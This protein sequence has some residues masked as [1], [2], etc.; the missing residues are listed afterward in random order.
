MPNRFLKE[1]IRTSKT[2]NA[3]N[4]FQFRVWAYLITYV[5]DFGR[6]SA[7][8]EIIKGFVFP[9]RKSVTE[10]SIKSALDDLA[11]M[12]LI[13]LYDVDGDSYLYFPN[14]AS[15]QNVRATS[16]KFPDPTDDNTRIQMKTDDSNCIQTIADAPVSR[17]SYL[18]TRNSILDTR[19][20]E[21]WSIYPNK[22][23]KK[24][25]ITAWVAG[26]CDKIADRIIADVQ[27][28]C[29]TEW[30]GDGSKYVPHPTTYIHQR[31]WEDETAPQERMERTR[32]DRNPND[33]PAQN[34]EQREYKD[35]DYGDNFFIDLDQYGE[36]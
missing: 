6:G 21:F 17:Y 36:V 32:L 19:F 3:L 13:R 10:A 29:D 30:K 24:D 27:K 23:K 14:W 9:R 1:S 8:P 16:S 28:R 12:G 2:I 15:H 33:N 7:E 25:T 31:R 18:D 26:K 11:R 4:D 5:D 20:S 34:Y 22:V 35:E